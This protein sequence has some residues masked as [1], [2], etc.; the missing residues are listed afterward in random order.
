M[1]SQYR[2]SVLL[3]EDD[4]G[5]AQL[6]RSLLDGCLERY[7]VQQ[8]ERL[9]Q[10]R[11]LNEDPFDVVVTDLSLPDSLGLETVRAVLAAFPTTAVVVMTGLSDTDTGLSAVQLGCQDYLVKGTPDPELLSRTLRYAVERKAS[12]LRLQESEERFRR[13]IQVSPDAI[14][15]VTHS[16]IEFANNTAIKLL[17]ANAGQHLQGRDPAFLGAANPQLLELIETILLG[18]DESGQLID[19]EVATLGGRRLPADIHAVRIPYQD[20][21]AV[22]LIIRDITDRRNAESEQRLASAVFRTTAEAMMVTDAAQRIIAINPAFS[23]ITGYRNEDIIG[24]PAALLDAGRHPPQF[25]RA[26]EQVLRQSG[27]WHGEVWNRRKDGTVFVQRRTISRI[28]ASQSDKER[29]VSVFSDITDQ[30][31]AEEALVHRANHDVLTGLPN[32]G[33][34][35]D[36]LRQA[37]VKAAR[38]TSQLALM[39]ID[40]DGFKAVNDSFGH[41]VGDQLLQRLA[42]RL[43]DCVRSSDTTARVGGDEFVV[44][45]ADVGSSADIAELA[46]KILATLQRP[47]VLEKG[48]T[49][50]VGA[51]IGIARYPDDEDRA[52][53][54]MQLADRAMY[55]AKRAGKGRIAF[56]REHQ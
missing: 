39:F 48:V 46:A 52:E 33:L 56:A 8:V 24:S 53:A 50:K 23:A 27:H 49:T 34:L 42:S 10:A 32:R 38:E 15:L 14:L 11:A 31:R 35:E 4:P 37:I 47:A 41:L 43:Q 12:A 22:Q 9:A 21:H 28:S 3:I 1:T 2:C 26:M 40:L 7:Q 44:L 18:R 29:F 54:L 45:A 25:Y 20:D 30:K 17:A 5:D 36:R 6:F 16:G 19:C 51:S 13:L 55:R